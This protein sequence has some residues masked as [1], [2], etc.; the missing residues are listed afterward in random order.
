MTMLEISRSDR[1]ENTVA[2]VDAASRPGPN[3]AS[4][5][6]LCAPRAV[7]PD[8]VHNYWRLFRI[9]RYWKS[10]MSSLFTPR[11]YSLQ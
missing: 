11:S 9:A 10:G 5:I 2:G 6:F 4:K 7:L 8:P 1:L 3:F